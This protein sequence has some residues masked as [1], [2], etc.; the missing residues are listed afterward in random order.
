MATGVFLIYYGIYG[1]TLIQSTR[2]YCKSGATSA[3]GKPLNF[4]TLSLW[5]LLAL[6]SGGLM[7]VCSHDLS[8]SFAELEKE[9]IESRAMLRQSEQSEESEDTATSVAAVAIHSWRY[10][11]ASFILF[12]AVMYFMKA[13]VIFP[14]ETCLEAVG[15]RGVPLMQNAPFLDK[16]RDSLSDF[17]QIVYLVAGLLAIGTVKAWNNYR[18][19]KARDAP[20]RE[21]DTEG[22]SG[23]AELVKLGRGRE[24][25]AP[26]WAA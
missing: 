14:M 12:A 5:C 17:Q 13:R 18:K 24:L 15:Q 8:A 20:Q 10:I 19:F 23:I 22:K 16:L 3:D 6:V 2:K 7:L 21:G 25:N 1:F 26:D 4:L 9:S 11:V